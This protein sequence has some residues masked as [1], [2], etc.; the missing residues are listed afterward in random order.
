M[1]TVYDNLELL[2]LFVPQSFLNEINNFNKLFI[3]NQ[4]KKY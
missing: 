3:E 1:I 2:T 4:K